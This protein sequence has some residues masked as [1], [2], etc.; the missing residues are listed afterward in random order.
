MQ[1]ENMT[2]M[3]NENEKPCMTL[4]NLLVYNLKKDVLNICLSNE[5]KIA[6]V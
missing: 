2:K 3:K 5:I 6:L 1:N 4:F